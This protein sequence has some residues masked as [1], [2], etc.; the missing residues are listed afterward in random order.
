MTCKLRHA[1][2]LYTKVRRPYS[3]TFLS[4]YPIFQWCVVRCGSKDGHQ[5]EIS[6]IEIGL[7]AQNLLA[8][9]GSIV[10]II[11]ETYMNI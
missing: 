1:R 7:H 6:L 8:I 4:E 9:L 10:N 11:G 3:A 2:Q 5:K